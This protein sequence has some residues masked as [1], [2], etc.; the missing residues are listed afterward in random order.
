MKSNDTT[1][2][3]NRTDLRPP[4]GWIRWAAFLL[5]L[6]GWWLSFDLLRLSL[7]QHASNPWL[8]TRCG[9]AADGTH[10]AFDCQSVLASRWAY[11]P[12]EPREGTTPLPI[13][14]LGMGYFAF[15]GLWYL[16]VGPPTRSRWPVHLLIV[17]VVGCGVVQSAQMVYVMAGVLHKWCE[18]CLAVH[19]LNGGLALLTIVAFPW[20]SDRPAQPPHPQTRLMLAT[21]AAGL[22]LFLLHPTSVRLVQSN[23]AARRVFDAYS[24]IVDDPEFVRW[25]YQRQPQ[26]TIATD[27]QR[28]LLGDPAAP[29]T[30]VLFLD[31]QCSACMTACELLGD[32]MQRHPGSLRVDCRH[33][34][35]HSGCNDAWPR[36]GDPAACAAAAA[37]E[38]ARMVGGAAGL[39]A[40]RQL[41]YRHRY[42]LHSA[43]YAAWAAEA[44]IDPAAFSAALVS[45]EV[46]H[47]LQDD[48]A[49][50]GELGI[51]AAPALFLNG[52]R[53]H[54]WNKP[55]TWEVLLG[56]APGSPATQTAAP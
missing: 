6:A 15:V 48:S 42:E 20:R 38:A 32:L 14:I 55:A 56:L 46:R 29:N 45:E 17:L 26:H 50:A 19:A 35:L 12:A 1:E 27:P 30:V 43:P 53:L 13:A 34:P 7:G 49:L 8:E 47:R 22:F 33:F 37:L 40:M 18:G 21:L 23:L 39:T 5:A 51:D 16:L 10:G 31:A 44:G 4:R 9:A 54:H 25:Q 24:R 41:I 3:Q 52:R 36:R 11:V 28:A 2:T